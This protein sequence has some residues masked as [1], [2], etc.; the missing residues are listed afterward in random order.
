MKD[1]S[2][3]NS[4]KSSY[5]TE[6]REIHPQKSM[7]LAYY[8]TQETEPQNSPYF[9]AQHLCFMNY[10]LFSVNFAICFNKYS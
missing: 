3:M 10:A 4:P 5:A 9:R 2:K 8:F 7:W 1:K 6:H